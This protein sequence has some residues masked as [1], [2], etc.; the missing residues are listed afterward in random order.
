MKQVKNFNAN[1]RFI[2]IDIYKFPLGNC[3]GV[4]D[5]VKD[6]YIPHERGNYKFSEI[7]DEKEVI[8]FPEQRGTNYFALI[9]IMQPEGMVGPMNGGNLA[10]SS[11]SRCPVPYHVHDRFETTEQY[12]AFSN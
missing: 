2:S 3:G 10:Y 7:E 8:F 6:I 4:T 1:D 12:A 5:N 11:D 9:P